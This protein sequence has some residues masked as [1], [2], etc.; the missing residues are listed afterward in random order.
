[1]FR[2]KE[3]LD[4]AELPQGGTREVDY[5]GLKLTVPDWTRFISTDCDG[6]IFAFERKP[7]FENEDGTWH[8][9][10]DGYCFIADIGEIS[11]PDET[12]LYCAAILPIQFSDEYH[13][14]KIRRG[15]FMG[16]TVEIPAK[17]RWIAHDANGEVWAYTEEPVW[18]D[19]SQD[20]DSTESEER[21]FFVGTLS[22]K[23][24]H[25]EEQA[26]QSKL[27]IKV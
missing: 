15:T 18:F 7:H 27:Q 21:P 20:W 3:I 13:A 17:Y 23:T 5:F 11:N 8:F 16:I 19:V 1:M 22:D 9:D 25:T 6:G 26:K 2:N 24:L 14:A 4:R 12:L 10:Y